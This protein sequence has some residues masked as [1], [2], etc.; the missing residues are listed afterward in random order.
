MKRSINNLLDDLPVLTLFT[1]QIGKVISS[2]SPAVGLGATQI[3]QKKSRNIRKPANDG[4]SN[5]MY[6]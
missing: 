3:L 5:Y 1:Q 2:S 4:N 6:M